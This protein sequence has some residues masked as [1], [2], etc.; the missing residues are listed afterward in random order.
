MSGPKSD[1]ALIVIDVQKAFDDPRWGPRNNPDAERNIARLLDRWRR[2]GR[3]VIHVKHD[4]VDPRSLLRPGLPGNEIKEEAL[5]AGGEPLLHKCVNSAFIGT[6]LEAR[7]RAMGV[8]DVVAVGITT[9]HCVST[10][11]RMAANLGFR[12]FVVSDA[13]ATFGMVSPAGRSYT[14]D[15]MHDMGLAELSGEFA[16]IVTTAQLLT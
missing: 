9:N 1:A 12:A 7:L 16:T 14:A 3:P 11:V 5:P 8:T 2:D 15:E 13:T 10:T 4:S 6:D